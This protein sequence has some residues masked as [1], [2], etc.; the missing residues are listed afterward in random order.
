M[1]RVT[2]KRGIAHAA[3]A[4]LQTLSSFNGKFFHEATRLHLTPTNVTEQLALLPDDWVVF[5]RRQNQLFLLKGNRVVGLRTSMICTPVPITWPAT[6]MPVPDYRDF[7]ANHNTGNFIIVCRGESIGMV[8]VGADGQPRSP[9][10]SWVQTKGK[11]AGANIKPS[12]NSHFIGDV[13]GYLSENKD[14]IDA[15]KSMFIKA[16]SAEMW[17]RLRRSKWHHEQLEEEA[18][19]PKPPIQVES[20]GVDMGR[21]TFHFKRKGREYAFDEEENSQAR[22]VFFDDQR[23][24]FLADKG[25]QLLERDVTYGPANPL[26]INMGAVIGQSRRGHISVSVP[27]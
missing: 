24:V 6:G 22:S 5:R 19:N 20:A 7:V 13:M 27:I 9:P 3:S 1:L 4:P 8:V 17:E 18:L 25:M 16:F 15:C 12:Y 14:E 23:F 10:R 26:D 2:R 11:V 21:P